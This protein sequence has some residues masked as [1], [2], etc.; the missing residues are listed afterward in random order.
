MAMG[1]ALFEICKEGTA[2][3]CIRLKDSFTPNV[4]FER[5]PGGMLGLNTDRLASSGKD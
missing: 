2:R 5:T 1:H 4:L 3:A